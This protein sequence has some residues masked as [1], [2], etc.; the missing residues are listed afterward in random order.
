MWISCKC[1]PAVA[2]AAVTCYP[3]NGVDSSEIV[4]VFSGE[5]AAAAAAAA[6]APSMILLAATAAAP[7]AKHTQANSG[8]S[9][10]KVGCQVS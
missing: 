1:W 6:V 4:C 10:L 2:W 5:A 3:N 9:L 8:P 7:P